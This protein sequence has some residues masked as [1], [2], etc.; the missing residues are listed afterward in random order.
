M[1]WTSMLVLTT[2]LALAGSAAR[3]DAPTK[4]YDP[5]AAFA[6]ADTDHDGQIDREE[7]QERIVEVFYS[8]DRNKDGFL[9]VEK[10][11]LLVFPDDFKDEDRDHDGHISMREFLRVRQ[12]DYDQ[13]DSDDDG[14]LSLDEVVAVYEKK[15]R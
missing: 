9:D 15:A 8:A 10:V 13:A 5:R 1:R 6:E 3:A 2:A 11:Q 12:H 7:F 14:F 4:A